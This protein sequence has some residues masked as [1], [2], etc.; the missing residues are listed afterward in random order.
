MPAPLPRPPLHLFHQI[1]ERLLE[2]SGHRVRLVE[3]GDGAALA[4]A[5]RGS[6]RGMAGEEVCHRLGQSAVKARE[7]GD[8][9]GEGPRGRN[10]RE[11][12]RERTKGV[13]LWARG[14]RKVTRWTRPLCEAVSSR[15]AYLS[16][17]GAQHLPR[18]PPVAGE[19]TGTDSVPGPEVACYRPGRELWQ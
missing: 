7:T 17:E 9:D 12:D 3:P 14:I 18:G 16:R 4:Q 8:R 19:R 2:L 10:E 11:R 13:S 6:L 5:L 15:L 1:Q